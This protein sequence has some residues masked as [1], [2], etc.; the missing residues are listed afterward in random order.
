VVGPSHTEEERVL[1]NRRLEAGFVVLVAAS[2]GL[3]ALT[4]GGSPAGVAVGVAAGLVVGVL[5]L[6]FLR[7]L[8]ADFSR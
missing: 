2:G 1:A 7:G 3:V 5:L 8:A 4:A 6:A